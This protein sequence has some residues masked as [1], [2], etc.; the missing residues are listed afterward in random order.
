MV[1]FCKVY[2]VINVKVPKDMATQFTEKEIQVV[3][4][5]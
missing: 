4:T 5:Q 1:H 2:E 3:L